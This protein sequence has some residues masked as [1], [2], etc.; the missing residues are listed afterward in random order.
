[1]LSTTSFNYEN[2]KSK[3]P[4][5]ERQ[6]ISRNIIAYTYIVRARRDSFN[7]TGI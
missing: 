4:L 3:L 6:R 7:V 2:M 5:R 1:L